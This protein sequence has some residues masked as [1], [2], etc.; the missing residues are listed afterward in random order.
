MANHV[1]SE[2]IDAY[3]YFRDESTADRYDI[4]MNTDP[5]APQTIQTSGAPLSTVWP[6]TGQTK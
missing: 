5:L 2:G 3:Y 1:P 4:L 6:Q